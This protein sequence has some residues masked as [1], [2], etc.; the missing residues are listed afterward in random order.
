MTQPHWYRAFGLLI[1]SDLD[2]PEY[3]PS[4]AG[5][6]D[7]RIRSGTRARDLR[8][9]VEAEV[10]D[11]RGAHLT[12][13]GML[14]HVERVGDYIIRDGH[15]ID[16]SPLPEVEI[17]MLRLYLV[18]SV[19]G[20]LMHQRGKFLL[21][22]AAV[23]SPKGVSVFVGPSGAGK[24]TLTLHLAKAGYPV[25]SDDTLPLSD[26]DGQIVA[27]PGA[28]LFKLW[29]DA[30]RV[31]GHTPDDLRKVSQRYGKYFFE[32]ACPAPDRATPVS[33][34]FVLERGDA[35]S[36]TPLSGLDAVTALNENTYRREYIDF[37]GFRERY[38]KQIGT[39]VQRLNF[40]RFVRPDDA[41]RI[42]DAVPTLRQHW[43]EEA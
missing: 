16:V 27:W 37:L 11:I 31:G 26:E 29:D 8:Q 2:L 33:E 32:H 25:L 42:S 34:V 22:G 3:R 36:I 41:Q 14:L 38:L 40:Y 12:P 28:Q 39:L 9:Q 43:G 19:M 35:F 17:D 15:E 10:E 24:S 21:H 13:D 23:L 4:E 6:E 5:R 20:A 18:G 7:I 30:L 1:R